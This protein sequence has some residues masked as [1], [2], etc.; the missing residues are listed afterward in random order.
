MEGIL[1]VDKPAGW[2]SHDVCAFVRK[3]FKIKKVGHA[4]TLDPM[5]T[6]VLVL[7][8]GSATKQSQQLSASDKEYAGNFELGVK[9]DSHDRTGKILEQAPWE[10]ITCEKILE[11]MEKFKGE[12]L[13]EPP[14]VS[15]LKHQ[16]VRLYELARKGL[17]VPREKRPI[18]IY[19][20]D[21][22]KKEGRSVEFSCRVS[23]GTYL[24]TLV[25]DLGEWLGCFA[26]L[27]ALKRTASGPYVIENSVTVDAL[28]TMTP[29][30]LQKRIVPAALP[31]NHANLHAR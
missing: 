3:Q 19:R 17:S 22:L 7:L 11:G 15:A 13:Q 9:T 29:E 27:S 31:A 8:L 2:T 24:R 16:G 20:W 26:V 25:H 18:T 10:D 1:I 30:A 14:M 5:A 6:G 21:L 12:I 23:K 4:G 28:R